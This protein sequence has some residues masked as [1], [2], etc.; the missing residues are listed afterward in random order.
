MTPL[1]T[2]SY[3][4]RAPR[5][6]TRRRSVRTAARL[7]PCSEDE[8]RCLGVRRV[9]AVVAGDLEAGKPGAPEHHQQFV[10]E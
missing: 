5:L 4:S 1:E 10:T 3:W 9:V 2:D 8:A 6:S 7:A